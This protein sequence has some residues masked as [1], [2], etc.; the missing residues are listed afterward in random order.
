VV[1]VVGGTNAGTACIEHR[2][3]NATAAEHLLSPWHVGC[4]VYL[5]PCQAVMVPRVSAL[6]LVTAHGHVAAAWYVKTPVAT[7]ISALL[8]LS[9]A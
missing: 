6:D 8:G 7:K 9:L 4:L 2:S 5:G 1:E 3:R